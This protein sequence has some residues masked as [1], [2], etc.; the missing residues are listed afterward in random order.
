MRHYQQLTL[1]EKMALLD[2]VKTESAKGVT[3]V[4][5][6]L[7]TLEV[8]VPESAIRVACLESGWTE[9]KFHQLWKLSDAS[10][11]AVFGL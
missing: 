5:D 2:L 7:V 4:F 8:F 11:V 10:T 6:L 3:E 9:G 1:R